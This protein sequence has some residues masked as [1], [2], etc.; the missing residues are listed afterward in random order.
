M[1]FIQFGLYMSNS[2]LD[3]VAVDKGIVWAVGLSSLWPS[4]D[5]WDPPVF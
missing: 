3:V 1:P 2:S 5:R 4:V